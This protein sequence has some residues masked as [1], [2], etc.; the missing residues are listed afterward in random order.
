MR[1]VVRVRVRVVV[2]VREGWGCG[3]RA[4]RLVATVFGLSCV[5]RVNPTTLAT[6]LPFR[7]LSGR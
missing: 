6:S 3:R 1:V 4:E 2:R 7:L 5:Y